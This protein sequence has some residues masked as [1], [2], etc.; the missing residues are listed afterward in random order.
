M[1]IRLPMSL[2]CRAGLLLAI[3]L[4][5]A[6]PAHAQPRK[7]AFERIT[8]ADGLPGGAVNGILQD[9]RGFMWFGTW[10]GLAR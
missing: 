3:V 8:E 4:L 1:Q 6:I 9:R 7:I 10:D 5:P 2:F